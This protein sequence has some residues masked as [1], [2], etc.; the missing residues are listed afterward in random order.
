MGDLTNKTAAAADARDSLGHQEHPW[1]GSG[2]EARIPN[3]EFSYAFHV[4]GT[5]LSGYWACD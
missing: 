4:S 5:P 3:A 1:A 2:A